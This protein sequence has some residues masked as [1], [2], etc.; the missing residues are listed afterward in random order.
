MLPS[1]HPPF[2]QVHFPHMRNERRTIYV[3]LA[4]KSIRNY[5]IF[6][7]QPYGS[8][9]LSL[10]ASD[11]VKAVTSRPA[12]CTVLAL[13]C[14]RSVLLGLQTGVACEGH[15]I[16]HMPSEHSSVWPYEREVCVCVCVCGG[17]EK[18]SK[19]NAHMRLKV[20]SQGKHGH[21]S[22]VTHT[23]THTHTVTVPDHVLLCRRCVL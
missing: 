21:T 8:E 23:H 20:P 3:E 14:H 1:H 4:V 11:R 16:L 9:S 17:E 6:P 15:M 7:S 22:V 10:H 19:A 13:C 5:I 18:Q 12:P 2:S